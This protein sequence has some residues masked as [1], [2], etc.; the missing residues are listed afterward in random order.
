MRPY[1]ADDEEVRRLHA[2][3]VVPMR[4][5]EMPSIGAFVAAL[6]HAVELSTMLYEG[7][8]LTGA[9]MLIAEPAQVSG[10]TVKLRDAAIDSMRALVAAASGGQLVLQAE[11]DG[12]RVVGLDLPGYEQPTGIRFSFSTPQRVFVVASGLLVGA[13]VV[14]QGI[15]VVQTSTSADDVWRPALVGSLTLPRL[16]T[17]LGAM[18]TH[19]H[20]GLLIVDPEPK[21]QRYGAALMGDIEPWRFGAKAAALIDDE[22]VRGKFLKSPPVQTRTQR[23]GMPAMHERELIQQQENR[24]SGILHTLGRLARADG[25][26]VISPALE[27]VA[28]GRSLSGSPP[29][30]VRLDALF[31]GPN[32]PHPGEHPPAVLGGTR[33]QAAACFVNENPRSIA[34]IV[35]SD[36][37]VKM[38]HGQDGGVRALVGLEGYL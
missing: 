22:K 19:R 5:L 4:G 8:P 31:A 10:F 36:G 12:L 9:L 16:H 32:G 2:A 18:R 21:N 14:G 37:P 13:S 35:S 1:Q 27:L 17:M 20:G 28:F 29:K 6:N 26:V 11:N 30:S 23:G 24:L 3:C 15:T 38:I 7:D 25:A 34:L 33:A